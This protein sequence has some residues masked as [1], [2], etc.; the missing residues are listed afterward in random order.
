MSKI[1]ILAIPPDSHGVGKYR[2]L[3]PYTYLQENYPDDFHIDIKSV[4]ENNDEEFNDYDIIVM[5]SFIHIKSSPDDNLKRIE[6][7]KKKGKIVIVD[8]DDYWE[9]DMRHPMFHQAKSTGIVA[10]KIKFI[11]TAN[12]VTVTTPIYQ[13]TI[14]KK[15][16]LKNVVVFP[17]AVNQNESQFISEPT[18]SEK[19]RFGWL[20]GSCLTPDTEILTEYGWK[21][22]EDLNENEKVATLN[23]KTNELEYHIPNGYIK[24]KHNGEIYTC[25]TNQ[26]SFSVTPN[27]N[28]YVSL[29]KW[30]GHK[31]P[32]F[33]LIM[34]E[35]LNG[36]NFHVKK[37][38][39]N[40]NKDIEYFILP[41]VDQKP[42]DKNNYSEKKILMDDWLVLFG[43]WIAEGWS[44]DKNKSI[45]VCQYKNNNYLKTIEN[46]FTK[47][48]FIYNYVKNTGTI[49]V[50]NRQLYEYFKQFGK[51]SDKFIPREYLNKLSERQLEILLD[52]YLKGDGSKDKTGKYI[53]Y[54]GY[55][56]SKQLAD[57]LMEIAFKIGNCASIKNRGK[58]IPSASLNENSKK[59]K[60]FPKHDLYQIGFYEKKSK[61]NKLMPIVRK[62][63]IKKTQYNGYVYCVNVQN[64][65][66]YV[67]RNGKSLWVG[68]SHLADIE[69]LREGIS[70]MHD[71]Y[72]DKIQFVLCGF[73][74][75]GSITEI[76]KQTGEKRTR[77]IKPEE[78]VWY[79]YEQIFTKNY[80]TLDSD[81]VNFLKSYKEEEYNDINKPYRRRWTKDIN[82]Y[83]TNYN[84][85][86]V[87]L[88][89]LVPS[90]FNGNKSP[91]KAVESGFHK[92]ALIASATD[93]YTIDL[94]SAID[95]GGKYNP[96]GN[97]LLV[98]PNKNH[99]QWFQHMK[100]LVE[101]P[102]MIEDLGNN[103]YE[104]V[105]DKYSLQKVTKDRSE[106][107]K[108]IIK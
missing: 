78:T 56:V 46:I 41:A 26:V 4:V 105:K 34:A 37:N 108:S 40:T 10:G 28:M 20:G 1:R 86:D 18:P 16:G 65:I 75:R 81:Y 73:D 57:D 24:E 43:F 100:R 80:T 22:F 30:M 17:N 64:N 99:K 82:K 87:S 96:K 45:S 89:P 106:F 11:Q 83:A 61:H 2:I 9:P 74:L 13:E 49:R 38:V 6:Y 52:W 76:N 25:D 36:C 50:C 91:L 72:N 15:F 27:H 92:K 53:R 69:L 98:D 47:Y 85:L 51:A 32:N 48:G 103:L 44:D 7:L 102:S 33:N 31:K 63:D 12:Y 14:R 23:P 39:V 21:F 71:T 67:R 70:L 97:A 66:I 3:D 35:K 58:R 95:F 54:R 104:T 77:P 62:E 42:L 79:K 88:A 84:H 55:T 94:V 107:L 101:N 19:I 5:H 93:P 8:F 90:V 29:I 59:R 60:I 68:N